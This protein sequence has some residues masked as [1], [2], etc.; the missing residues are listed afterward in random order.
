M[1]KLGVE[2]A[3]RHEVLIL[4]SLDLQQHFPI[5]YI[6]HAYARVIGGDH[7]AVLGDFGTLTRLSKRFWNSTANRPAPN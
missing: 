4:V 3:S 5:L 7:D 1:G 6:Y 2:R